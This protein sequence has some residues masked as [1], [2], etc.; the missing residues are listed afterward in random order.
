[1]KHVLLSCCL[2]VIVGCGKDP[3]LEVFRGTENGLAMQKVITTYHD[4]SGDKSNRRIRYYTHNARTREWVSFGTERPLREADTAE[5]TENLKHFEGPPDAAPSATVAPPHRIY[6]ANNG[7]PNAIIT[8]DV[9][10]LN[11][12]ARIR[13]PSFIAA[14]AA[15]LNGQT[16]VY[17]ILSSG[18]PQIIALDVFTNTPRRTLNLPPTAQVHSIVYSPDG[19]RL[20]VADSQLGIHIIDPAQLTLLQTVPRPTGITELISAAISPNGDLLVVR[21][22]GMAGLSIFDLTALQWTSPATTGR[23]VLLGERPCVF[24]P[25][26]HEFYCSS[27]DGIGIFDAATMTGQSSIT[28]PRGEIL[29]RFTTFDVGAYLLVTKDKAVRMIRLDT[30]TVEATLNPPNANTTFTTAYLVSQF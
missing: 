29:Y 17:S 13:V 15:A 3:T 23:V 21:S 24:H 14:L 18:T 8:L 10:S 22:S 2:I 20:F 30:R 19:K 7:G 1:M 12:V 4:Q 27:S 26:G 16:V 6:L 28:I 5:E 11:E 25:R 9:D